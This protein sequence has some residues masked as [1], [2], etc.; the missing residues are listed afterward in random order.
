MSRSSKTPF[1]TGPWLV[2]PALG[3]VSSA[4]EQHRLEPQVMKV[5]AYLAHRPGEVVARE[6]LFADLWPGAVVH[7]MALT[8]CITQIRKALGDDRT[9]PQFIATIP[10]TGYRFVGPVAP[11]S[12]QSRP[13]RLGRLWYAGATAAGAML[14]L[15]MGSVTGQFNDSATEALA[16]A[17]PAMSKYQKGMEHYRRRTYMENETAIVS[18]EKAVE[19]DPQLSLGYSGLADALTMKAYHW[20]GDTLGHAQALA[21]KAVSLDPSSPEAYKSLGLALA[22][23]GDV[24][25]AVQAQ[26]QAL[27]L[28][29]G[30]WEAAK[31]L[32]LLHYIAK[33]LQAAAV[34][35]R[36]AVRLNPDDAGSMSYLGAIFLMLG[37]V[38]EAGIWLERT[39]E[40]E[41]LNVRANWA[42]AD[43]AI[44]QGRYAD[45]VEQCEALLRALPQDTR[46][47]TNAA[48]AAYL[49]GDYVKAELLYR[50]L[51]EVAPGHLYAG[52]GQAQVA[53]ATGRTQRA[54]ALLSKVEA[55][56]QE[57]IRTGD[58]R[59]H[60][61]WS[62]A[63]A[64]ALQGE[65]ERAMRWLDYT[66]ESGRSY[67]L[68][69]QSDPALEPLRDNAEFEAYLAAMRERAAEVRRTLA[70]NSI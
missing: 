47:L 28:R 49:A 19:L 38:D 69:D 53:L 34:W 12:S 56:A 65:E 64:L 70:K 18:F 22:I 11:V 48:V 20:R 55:D 67:Y 30:Y 15:A 32:A 61:T 6:Q 39:Y 60:I 25:R 68:W 26:H 54:R 1:R 59:W 62:L 8:R 40:R 51:S 36:R 42:L 9:R 16:A 35:F 10:K 66:L 17:T 24:P 57:H 5:L 27:A 37:D 29:P 46:C 63:A 58:P 23:K 41:P 44:V 2:E 13:R 45:A 33:D 3:R 7:D 52:L 50:Q 21:E 31:N 43:L 4:A 14:V